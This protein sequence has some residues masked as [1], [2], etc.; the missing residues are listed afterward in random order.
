MK[1]T[2]IILSADMGIA[3]AAPAVKSAVPVLETRDEPCR[4]GCASLQH[5]YE[6]CLALYLTCRGSYHESELKAR[7]VSA[8]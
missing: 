5:A 1:V 3:A 7:L 8:T 6:E 4:P 2:A